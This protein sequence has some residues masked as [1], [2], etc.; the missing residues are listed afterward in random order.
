MKWEETTLGEFVTPRR[1]YDLPDHQ[2][3]P[4]DIPIR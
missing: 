4:G 1:G 3:K 2:R